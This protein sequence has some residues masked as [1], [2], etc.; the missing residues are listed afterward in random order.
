MQHLTQTVKRI[1]AFSAQYKIDPWVFSREC[2]AA[3]ARFRSS[4]CEQKLR[5]SHLQI[6]RQFSDLFDIPDIAGETDHIVAAS[7]NFAVNI[8]RVVIDG[9]FS[10]FD[11]AVFACYDGIQ[12][13]ERQ[14]RMH[15]F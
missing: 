10:R 5:A 4:R 13:F 11:I 7:Q 3:A 9:E 8:M 14:I 2:G 15:I 12:V 1:L 6:C